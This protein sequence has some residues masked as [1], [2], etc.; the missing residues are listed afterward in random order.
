MYNHLSNIA[1]C[2]VESPMMH[3]MLYIIDS[4]RAAQVCRTR[5]TWD[6]GPGPA[7]IPRYYNRQYTLYYYSHVYS[8]RLMKF[9]PATFY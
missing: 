1:C 7:I 4:A 6:G 2:G 3:D 8:R 5:P 9:N